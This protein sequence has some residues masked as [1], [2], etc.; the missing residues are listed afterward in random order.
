[1][2]LP[3][4]FATIPKESVEL[5][6]SL[7]RFCPIVTFRKMVAKFCKTVK[8]QPAMSVQIAIQT[9]Q[10]KKTQTKQKNQPRNLYFHSSSLVFH[11][12]QSVY[13]SPAVYTIPPSNDRSF[14]SHKYVNTD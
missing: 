9:L 3:S 7:P 6:T 1:M 10:K 14:L 4:S 13:R 5:Y 11:A 8:I 2:F 12:M